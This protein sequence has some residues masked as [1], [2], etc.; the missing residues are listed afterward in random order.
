MPPPTSVGSADRQ[1]VPPGWLHLSLHAP[2][3]HDLRMQF[4]SDPV[5]RQPPML[6]LWRTGTDSRITHRYGWPLVATCDSMGT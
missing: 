6:A 5:G 2:W 3:L 4:M 1:T